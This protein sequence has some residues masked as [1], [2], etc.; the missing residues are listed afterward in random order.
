MYILEGVKQMTPKFT[1]ENTNGF[2]EE[3]IAKMNRIF[4]QKIN[5]L[6]EEDRQNKSYQ[7]YIA[8]QILSKM[9]V[10]L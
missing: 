10:I 4:S 6:P 2:T 7:D 9:A 8:E 5:A 1:R 3:E